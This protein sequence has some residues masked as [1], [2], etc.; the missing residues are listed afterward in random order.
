[1]IEAVNRTV[2]SELR[3][4]GGIKKG[5]G[6]KGKKKK[7]RQS[8]AKK[9]KRNFQSSKN[10]SLFREQEKVEKAQGKSDPEQDREEKGE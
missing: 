9:E 2:E 6:K 1:M 10:S 3:K 7:N 4:G 8:E 5:Q